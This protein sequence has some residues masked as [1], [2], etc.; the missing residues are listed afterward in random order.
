VNCFKEHVER[1]SQKNNDL[2][3]GNVMNARTTKQIIEKAE[4][5]IK[6]LE[7]ANVDCLAQD[8]GNNDKNEHVRGQGGNCI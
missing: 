4:Q 1:K 3:D 2:G 6:R 8:H 7:A 5:D